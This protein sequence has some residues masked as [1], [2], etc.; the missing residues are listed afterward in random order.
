MFCVERLA[1]LPDDVF[2]GLHPLPNPFHAL[3]PAPARTR[4]GAWVHMQEK[5]ED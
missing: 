3:A 2:Q 4:S 5:D 1:A